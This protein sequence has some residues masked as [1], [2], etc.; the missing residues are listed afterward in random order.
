MQSTNHPSPDRSAARPCRMG[1]PLSGDSAGAGWRLPLRVAIINLGLWWRLASAA[2]AQDAETFFHEGA[3]HY[4]ATN[5]LAQA[6]TVVSNGLRLHPDNPKLQKLWELLN[7][8]QQQQQDQ[9]NQ[10]QNQQKD[11]QDPK[12][13]NPQQK[14]D[15]QKGGEQTPDQKGSQD[16]HSQRQPGEQKQDQAQNPSPPGQPGQEPPAKRDGPEGRLARMSPQQAAQLLDAHK[17]EERTLIF[18]PPRTNRNQR[19]FRDW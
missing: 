17:G 13:Q 11:Q 9:Q 8:R 1:H 18:T 6:I 4:L 5:E 7:Q 19:V 12:D 15:E 14:Q 3:R 2:S 10:Q 16:D